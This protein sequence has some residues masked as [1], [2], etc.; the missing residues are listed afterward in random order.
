VVANPKS[1]LEI[2]DALL[3]VGDRLGMRVLLLRMVA[4]ELPD[5][6]WLLDLRVAHEG[7]LATAE[8][9][10]LCGS[11][12][13]LDTEGC[14]TAFKVEDAITKQTGELYAITAIEPGEANG[15][16]VTLKRLD[17]TLR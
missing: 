3:R 1:S 4:A 13:T 8:T 9:T 2:E 14:L 12:C 15:I 5:N 17:A 16:R 6:P 10:H 11:S 7:S